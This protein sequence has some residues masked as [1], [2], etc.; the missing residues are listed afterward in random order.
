MTSVSGA[1]VWSATYSS[2]LKSNVDSSSTITNNLRAPGQYFDGEI[3]LHY[4]YHRYYDP[5]IGRYVKTDPIRLA[6]GINLY[7]YI[8]NNPA[9]NRDPEGL[10]CGSG[11][12]EMIVPDKPY[13][14]NFEQPCWHH[15][16]CY[17]NCSKTKRQCDK[18]FH[19]RMR[20]ICSRYY[21]T[22]PNNKFAECNRTADTYYAAV[23]FLGQNPWRTAQ[24]ANNCKD[25]FSF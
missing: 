1:V 5:I 4:N 25:K 2:F 20:N 8:S 21:A 13:G 22:F 9:N 24:C 10:Y 7:A 14:Y 17:G 18:E 12:T 11:S 15:D 16:R 3:G 23:V 19:L 6:G